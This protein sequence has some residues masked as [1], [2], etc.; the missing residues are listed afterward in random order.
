MS[1][2][3][4]S[5]SV[6]PLGKQM[7]NMYLKNVPVWYA[8]VHKPKFKYQSD[9]EKE[10][11]L[12]VFV[13]KATFQLMDSANGLDKG[14]VAINKQFREVGVDKNKNRKV[15]F[16]LSSQI[17][18]DEKKE[19]SYDAVKGM[20]GASLCLA[21]ISKKGKRNAVTVI[22]KPDAQGVIQEF[23]RDIGNG[24][25]CNIKLFGYVNKEGM[26]NIQLDTVQV[27][28]HVPY[29]GGNSD[30]VDDDEF[31]GAYVRAPRVEAEAPAPTNNAPGAL[32]R[33]AAQF[34]SDDGAEFPEE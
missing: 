15:K 30:T 14:F 21:E 33:A 8:A 26:L 20:Y 5:V 2:I 27:L 7:Y 13:D 19:Y 28:E 17:E 18:D 9:T 24:S 10:F 4:T 11:S 3:K 25:I 34:E 32:R 31:G 22:G 6:K 29:V 23:T 12:T 16:P 1:K